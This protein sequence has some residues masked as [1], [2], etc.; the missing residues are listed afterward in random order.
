MLMYAF[1]ENSFKWLKPKEKGNVIQ[2]N[3]QKNLALLWNEE[4]KET[5]EEIHSLKKRNPSRVLRMKPTCPGVLL[6]KLFS[7]SPNKVKQKHN[8]S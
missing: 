4:K 6:P 1:R 5:R 3:I 7:I 8:N 2:V